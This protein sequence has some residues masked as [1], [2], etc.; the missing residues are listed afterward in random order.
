MTGGVRLPLWLRLAGP[1]V[2][3]LGGSGTVAA[4]AHRTGLA[5]VL[6]ILSAVVLSVSLAR[7]LRG[8]S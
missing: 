3:V 2:A 7:L 1:T 8:R 4:S 5:A 6:V